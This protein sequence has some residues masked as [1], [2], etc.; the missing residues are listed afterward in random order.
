MMICKGTLSLYDMRYAVLLMAVFII[1]GKGYAGDAG[2]VYF[3]PDSL[4]VPVGQAFTVTLHIALAPAQAKPRV[5]LEAWQALEACT[6]L[7]AGNVISDGRFASQQLTLLALEPGRHAL[8][9]LIVGENRSPP[10][11]L[12]V[13]VPAL[14]DG[15]QLAPI[16]DIISPSGGMAS[17]IRWLLLLFLLL[18][19]VAVGYRRRRRSTAQPEQ[20]E[21]PVA[22]FSQLQALRESR[23]W[24]RSPQEFHHQL[25]ALLLM[26]VGRQIPALEGVMTSSELLRTLQQQGM[27]AEQRHQLQELLMASAAVKFAKAENSEAENSA[28]MEE[29][30]RWA[31]VFNNK[32]LPDE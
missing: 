12:E 26:L 18:L 21:P 27:P 25:S 6:F 11:F 32:H 3:A 10:L 4:R 30:L 17:V 24:V 9:G 2:L 15:A 31:E 28:L 23:L 14:A 7:R 1:S 16:G 29:A 13:Y 19:V 20:R 22:I 8:P 5:A